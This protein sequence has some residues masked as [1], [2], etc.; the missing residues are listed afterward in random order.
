M[1]NSFSSDSFYLVEDAGRTL[2]VR[3]TKDSVDSREIYGQLSRRKF[4]IGSRSFIK[5]GTPL[6]N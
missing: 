1:K 2:L 5:F 6:A 4:I 3:V